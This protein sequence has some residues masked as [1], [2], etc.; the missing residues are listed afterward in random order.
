M[1]IRSSYLPRGSS[2]HVPIHATFELRP[3]GK[4]PR[5]S[6]LI[7]QFRFNPN[8][9]RASSKDTDDSGKAQIYRD[10]PNCL[11]RSTLCL[12]TNMLYTIPLGFHSPRI[13]RRT[14]IFHH[15]I[16]QRS[17]GLANTCKA[18]TSS[19]PVMCNFKNRIVTTLRFCLQ[20]PF[21]QPEDAFS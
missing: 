2:C 3:L 5:L 10:G 4:S 11:H 21:S 1:D 6:H 18:V 9:A 20:K 16:I 7:G 12:H 14:D 15:A 8:D 17:Q 13:L 19:S